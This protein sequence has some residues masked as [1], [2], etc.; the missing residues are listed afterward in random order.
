[1]SS[2]LSDFVMCSDLGV[3]DSLDRMDFMEYEEVIDMK[4]FIFALYK[5]VSPIIVVFGI[6]GNSL[7]LV[8][9]IR[10]VVK[11]CTTMLLIGLT[12]ADLAFLI[13]TFIY[14]IVHN[15]ELYCDPYIQ[16]L[17]VSRYH[18][19]RIVQFPERIS[20][21]CL[22]LVTLERTCAVI[23]PFRI[24]EVWT[25]SF[26]VKLNVLACLFC[27]IITIPLF[28][29]YKVNLHCIETCHLDMFPVELTIAELQNSPFLRNYSIFIILVS[30]AVP[31]LVVSILNTVIICGVFSSA[32]MI[33]EFGGQNSRIAYIYEKKLTITLVFIS[34]LYLLCTMPF[35]TFGVLVFLHVSGIDVIKMSLNSLILVN[36][37]TLT[38]LICTN[39][40]NF[41]IYV[42]T[43]SIYRKKY[44]KVLS[45]IFC[46][47]TKKKKSKNVMLSCAFFCK[48]PKM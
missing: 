1:M 3:N 31:V 14:I 42:F 46:V 13:L 38:L 16:Q 22:I 2:N 37:L 44:K 36:M 43:N 24:R 47:G 28:R 29:S 41:I 5:I 17:S 4:P 25:R 21:M 20:R 18:L 33:R 12:S 15:S 32:R 10:H 23:F 45:N 34:I 39:S 6:L 27:F 30:D 8:V 40:F 9:L 19:F 48:N 11:T 35:D 26:G 7:T